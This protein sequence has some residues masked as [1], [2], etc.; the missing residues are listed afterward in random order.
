MSFVEI[1]YLVGERTERKESYPE[2]LYGVSPFETRR[3][4]NMGRT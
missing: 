3:R 4:S 1:K 2:Y